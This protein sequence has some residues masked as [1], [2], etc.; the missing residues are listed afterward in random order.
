M[1]SFT[2]ICF[3]SARYPDLFAPA[4]PL[5]WQ[6][7]ACVHQAPMYRPSLGLTHLS[8]SAESFW[9][10]HCSHSNLRL[11]A[12]INVPLLLLFMQTWEPPVADITTFKTLHVAR[13]RIQH[14]RSSERTFWA[15]FYERGK[16]CLWRIFAA[17]LIADTILKELA[18]F[19][20][21]RSSRCSA[22]LGINSLK[23]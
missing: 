21:H 20:R 10:P 19:P 8:A 7:A 1:F 23:W 16:G 13:A 9:I 2:L 22:S 12:D 4:C 11:Q 5:Q 3:P 17:H 14:V 6:I 18:I 15:C